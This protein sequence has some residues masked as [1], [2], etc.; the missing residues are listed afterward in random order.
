[1]SRLRLLVLVIASLLLAARPAAADPLLTTPQ[2]AKAAAKIEA[3]LAKEAAKSPSKPSA[4]VGIIQTPCDDNVSAG[5]EAAHATCAD[6]ETAAWD[7]LLNQ[8]WAEL[9][10][11]MDK[12]KFDQLKAVQKMWLAYRDAKCAYLAKDDETMMG[13]MNAA[14][15]RLDE[16]SRRTLELRELGG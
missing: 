7:L 16:T 12:E 1:M 8:R 2:I 11:S 6:N 9:A 10:Q 15:C 14:F 3:C 13:Y 5:G 4:C